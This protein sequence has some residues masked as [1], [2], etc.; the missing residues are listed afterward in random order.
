LAI[1]F[2]AFILWNNEAVVYYVTFDMRD[3][4]S[5]AD[6]GLKMWDTFA[7]ATV[8][9]LKSYPEP[10]PLL[11]APHTQS[12]QPQVSTDL[13]YCKFSNPFYNLN[14]TAGERAP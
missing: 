1:F 14:C 5:Y 7:L 10:S 6:P 2:N 9:T 11:K 4:T 13:G 8:L 12:V 3:S